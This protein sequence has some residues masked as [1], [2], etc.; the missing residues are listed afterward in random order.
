MISEGNGFT[1]FKP[2]K[3]TEL[4]G[5]EVCLFVYS[6]ILYPGKCTSGSNFI[7]SFSQN[8]RG[9]HSSDC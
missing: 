7:L 3:N 6:K 1:Q 2:V 8:E 5:K 4:I 9:F